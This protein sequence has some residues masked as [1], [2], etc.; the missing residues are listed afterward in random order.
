MPEKASTPAAAQRA[1]LRVIERIAGTLILDA[2]A[3]RLG[4]LLWL[5]YCQQPNNRIPPFDAERIARLRGVLDVRKEDMEGSGRLVPIPGG[6]RVELRRSD[7][8]ERRNFT[9]AHEIGHTY[10]FDLSQREPKRL[11]GLDPHAW[12]LEEAFCD[13]FAESLLMPSEEMRAYFVQLPRRIGFK[14][15]EAAAR[16]FRTTVKS[17]IRR[18]GKLSLLA[19]LSLFLF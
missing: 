10:F 18:T 11:I 1:F 9:C 17:T 19:D 13:Y 6:F 8:P 14:D 16:Y 7:R 12:H 3:E 2:A 4:R 5:D 15:F